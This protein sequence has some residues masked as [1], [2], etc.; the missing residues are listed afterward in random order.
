MAGAILYLNSTMIYLI[1]TMIYIVLVLQFDV[2]VHDILHALSGVCIKLDNSL[3]KS[4][5]VL[6]RYRVIFHAQILSWS[7]GQLSTSIRL[8]ASLIN[9]YWLFGIQSGVSLNKTGMAPRHVQLNKALS[10]SVWLP[11]SR[12]IRAKPPDSQCLGY[13]IIQ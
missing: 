10:N 2:E 8:W 9:G 4:Y 12:L 5:S 3:R 1:C 7:F 13:T 6:L 11:D